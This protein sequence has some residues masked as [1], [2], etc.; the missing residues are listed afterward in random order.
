MAKRKSSDKIKGVSRR[1]MFQGAAILIRW[2]KG[3]PVIV[4]VPPEPIRI[5]KGEGPIQ[6]SAK[7]PMGSL[8]AIQLTEGRKEFLIKKG[9]DP[10]LIEKGLVFDVSDS[11]AREFDRQREALETLAAKFGLSGKDLGKIP[12]VKRQLAKFQ[13]SNRMER[14]AKRG[15]ESL[16]SS[17][18]PKKEAGRPSRISAAERQ[19][20]R[21]RAIEMEAAGKTRK[22]IAMQFAEEYELGLSYV[23][24]ILEDRLTNRTEEG[25]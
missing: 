23:L 10:E 18:P 15:L 3:P 12:E 20:M 5:R 6:V 2:W 16:F 25:S 7:I 8:R 4:F 9:M 21:A 11:L 14:L 19:G 22:E 17:K 24:R 13:P 1:V